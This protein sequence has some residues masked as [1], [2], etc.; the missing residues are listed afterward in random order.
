MQAEALGGGEVVYA[1]PAHLEEK[2]GENQDEK[3]E[4]ISS[5][6]RERCGKA[7]L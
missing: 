2:E 6:W 4:A 1:P 5:D 7:H 3:S